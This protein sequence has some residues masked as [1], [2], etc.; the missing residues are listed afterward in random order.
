MRILA[1]ET[2]ALVIDLQEKLLPAMTDLP[3]LLKNVGAL[4]KGLEIAGVPVIVT[5]QYKKGLGGTP[6]EIIACAKDAPVIEKMEFSCYDN[7]EV[8]AAIQASQCKNVIICGIEAHICVL[9]TLIDLR[10]AGYQVILVEDCIQSRKAHDQDMALKR[11]QHEGAIITTFES[12]LFELVRKSG[13]PQF[14]QL[15]TLVKSL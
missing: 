9:Q 5:E 3:A 4:V 12:I 7:Q 1:N 14:K 8:Q 13:T 11:A 10:A 6:D 15:S 2:I